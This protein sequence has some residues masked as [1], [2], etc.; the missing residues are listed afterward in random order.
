MKLRF[1][2]L[3]AFKLV[4]V[5]LVVSLIFGVFSLFSSFSGASFS[6][7]EKARLSIQAVGERSDYIH[8]CRCRNKICIK[9]IADF[10]IKIVG[11]NCGITD[12]TLYPG[13]KLCIYR[14]TTV[15]FTFEDG[16]ELAV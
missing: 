12:Y 14:N 15:T 16:S 5:L 7:D 4:S 11:S 8:A 10:D 1:L 2:E 9:N 13:E 3:R 6:D